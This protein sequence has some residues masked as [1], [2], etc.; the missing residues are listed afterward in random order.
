MDGK[1]PAWRGGLGW[2]GL[3]LGTAAWDCGLGLRAGRSGC[4]LAARNY[5][6]NARPHA[7]SFMSNDAAA[8][9]GLVDGRST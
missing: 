4:S 5:I 3:V 9:A 6:V 8:W 7:A 2:A 1:K